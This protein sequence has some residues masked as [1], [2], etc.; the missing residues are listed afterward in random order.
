MRGTFSQ[1]WTKHTKDVSF[2]LFLC[3]FRAWAVPKN[4]FH[5]TL[6]YVVSHSGLKLF[7]RPKG[8]TTACKKSFTL[9]NSNCLFK[10]RKSKSAYFCY[11]ER[12][13]LRFTLSHV[14][15]GQLKY[16]CSLTLVYRT[17][18]LLTIGAPLWPMRA[19]AGPRVPFS[20]IQGEYNPRGIK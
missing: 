18:F 8:F 3:Q 5:I 17:V 20:L 9:M 19:G 1:L 16:C 7:Y 12:K 15:L 14:T 10:K 4:I 2:P 11:K 6:I 13:I